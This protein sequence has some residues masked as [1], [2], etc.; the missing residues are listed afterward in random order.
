MLSFIPKKILRNKLCIRPWYA[1]AVC[2]F[3]FFAMS[4]KNYNVEGWLVLA[5][6]KDYRLMR[7]NRC[8]LVFLLLLPNFVL[9]V[10]PAH[11]VSGHPAVGEALHQL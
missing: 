11:I 2:F 6:E 8:C 10:L 9:T 7:A 5:Y 4:E 3:F 1:L